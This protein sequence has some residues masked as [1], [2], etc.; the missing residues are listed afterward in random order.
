MHT[1]ALT[2]VPQCISTTSRPTQFLHLV[3]LALL[4]FV[5]LANA[6]YAQVVS[7]TIAG[8]VL[9][10]SGAVVPGVNIT[11]VDTETN[12][13]YKAV[14]DQSGN[15]TL[16]NLP[17]STYRVMVEHPGFAKLTVGGVVV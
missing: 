3:R 7:G 16:T 10:P 8:S 12:Q 11:A 15:Y 9:D 2:R 17:N 4:A 13:S 14:S 5:F 1:Q 6:A